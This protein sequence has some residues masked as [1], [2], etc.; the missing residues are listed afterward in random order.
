[1]ITRIREFK[2]SASQRRRYYPEYWS[3]LGWKKAIRH[4]YYGTTFSQT[5]FASKSEGYTLSRR[6]AERV[7]EEMRAFQKSRSIWNKIL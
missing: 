1:M 6:K 4:P 2:R 3:W 7:L 5:E